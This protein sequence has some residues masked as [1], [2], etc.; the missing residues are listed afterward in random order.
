MILSK[1][2]LMNTIARV[3]TY[4]ALKAPYRFLTAYLKGVIVTGPISP[5]GIGFQLAALNGR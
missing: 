4:K 2:G 3:K 1:R 5:E